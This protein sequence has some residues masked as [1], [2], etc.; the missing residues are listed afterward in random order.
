MQL[1][2]LLLAQAL[3]QGRVFGL[4]TQTLFDIGMQLLN[5]IILAVVLGKILYKPVME[6]LEKRK[7]I[8][9][10]KIND[11]DAAKAEAQGLIR[12]YEDKLRSIDEERQAVLAEA[13]QRGEEEGQDIVDEAR[14]EAALIRRRTT[15]MV[16]SERERLEDETR[17]Y[18]IELAT[19]V[20]EK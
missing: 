12:E 8:I 4:D 19:A 3:P 14:E 1:R 6:I 10:T 20:A 18:I 16:I 11:S 17:L 15:E 13:R 9:Q 7:E 5:G 2:L